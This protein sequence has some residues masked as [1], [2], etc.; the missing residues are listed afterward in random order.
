MPELNQL[1]EAQRTIYDGLAVGVTVEGIAKQLG[2]T[3]ALVNANITR[4]KNKGF[5]LPSPDSPKLSVPATNVEPKDLL[6]PLPTKPVAAGG[7]E[8]DRIAAEVSTGGKAIS[9]EELRALADKVAGNAAREI[10]P[11]VLMGIAIQF[12]K[13]CGGRM[14]A[15]QVIED[16]Y[17]A[18]R[19][20]AV[21]NGKSV[22]ED[23]G[24][25]TIPLPAG[26]KE[27]LA[28]MEKQVKDQD[29]KISDLQAQL[30]KFTGA[31]SAYGSSYGGGYGN[32]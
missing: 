5:A 31:P 1:T 14:T 29:S 15:H 12:V 6:G 30:R 11:M 19:S 9:A 3:V 21:E 2:T 8:N 18:L 28:F 17:G 16:V 22:P 24:G 32:N 10:H 7:T 26:D 13:L 27:R 23:T 4:I 25:E 20:F